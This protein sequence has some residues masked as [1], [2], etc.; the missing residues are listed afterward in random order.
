MFFGRVC[1]IILFFFLSLSYDQDMLA[2]NKKYKCV[3]VGAGSAGLQCA[4][5]LQSDFGIPA[6]QVLVLEARSTVGGR[7]QQTDT[8]IPGHKV[9]LGA[10]VTA[11]N[12]DLTAISAI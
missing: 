10:E 3:V 11:I 8:F 9:E 5:T 1:H 12:Y 7:V 6:S 4:R 2:T